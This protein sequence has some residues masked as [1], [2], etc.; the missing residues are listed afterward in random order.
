[1]TD[2]ILDTSAL[3]TLRANE[4]G[5]DV[6]E[7]ILKK[8]AANKHRCFLSFI[9]LTEIFYIVFQR[10]GKDEAYKTLA[11]IKTLPLEI[12]HPSEALLLLAGEWKAIHPMSL[13]DSF[14][15]ATA[16]LQN[17]VLVHKDP[18]FEVLQDDIQLLPLPYKGNSKLKK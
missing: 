17:A 3:L 11:Q 12:I 8:T 6:I 15:A 16:H 1:M 13:A 18:E 10:E 7:D 5:A 14:V 4:E 2:F 9:S